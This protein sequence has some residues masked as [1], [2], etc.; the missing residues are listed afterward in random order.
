MANLA[1]SAVPTAPSVRATLPVIEGLKKARTG[2]KGLDEITNGGLPQ[3]RPTLVCGTAGCGKTLFSLEFLVRG[4]QEFGE[5]GVFIAFAETAED[6]ANNVASLGF[7]L[8]TLEAEGKIAIDHIHIDSADM[9]EAGA[10]DLEG[11]FIRLELAIESV[12]AKRVVLDTLETIFGG[13]TDQAMLRAELR[14]LFT[15]LK[16]RNLTVVITG[17][18][19]EG[20]LTRQ[21][22][23]EYVSDC[24]ILLDH[25]VVDQ[26]STRRLR[27]VKYRGT[28]HGTNEYPFLIDENGFSVLP[29]SSLGL[30]H[31]ASSERVS[32]GVRALDEM[33]GGKG[34]FRGSSVLV[35]GTAGSGKTSLSAHFAR[36]ACLRGERVVY[37]A[38]EESRSQ[39]LRNMLSLGI[40]LAP[41]VENGLFHFHASRPALHGLEMHLVRM[42]KIIED[43][44]PRVVII[45]PITNLTS[46][47]TLAEINSMLVR[48][49]DFLK[50]SSITAMFTSLTSGGQAEEDTDVGVSSLTDTWLLVRDFEMGGERT[51]GL[52]IRKSRGMPHSNR[53]R[54]IVMTPQG[55]DLLPVYVGPN[56]VLTGSAR[57]QQARRDEAESEELLRDLQSREVRMDRRREAVQAQVAAMLAELAAEEV[58]MKR[59]MRELRTKA[60]Q[61]AR[62]R[63]EDSVATPESE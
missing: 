54:E 17:E 28:H 52:Y 63:D 56:S 50:V 53:V 29:L 21:G 4:V 5:P 42:H 59:A 9:A 34:F 36:A 16:E 18:R 38:F 30:D 1:I 44:A 27:I 31:E 22:L 57:S 3:G 49:I 41:F 7:D 10:Y 60:D 55:I 62:V 24:V 13:F 23:E 25:R 6:L 32:S 46:L 33:L 45:D 14:R 43:A 26:I 15:W 58:D 8:R 40:D 48:L 47:G 37:F 11:L 12:G 19:G 20:Q 35:S 2:I 39:L 51:R 61:A